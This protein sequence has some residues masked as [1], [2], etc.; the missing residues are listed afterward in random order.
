M[1]DLYDGIFNHIAKTAAT[2]PLRAEGMLFSLKHGKLAANMIESFWLYDD[3]GKDFLE[4]AVFRSK[5]WLWL[6][7]NEYA[8]GANE[9]RTE[10]RLLCEKLAVDGYTWDFIKQALIDENLYEKL[11]DEHG[12]RDKP[13]NSKAVLTQNG[14]Q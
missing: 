9:G 13:S 6:C 4:T 7:S 11:V 3:M 8:D 12:I 14:V 1:N 2:D 10:V 5:D